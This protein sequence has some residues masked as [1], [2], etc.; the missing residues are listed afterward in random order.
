M[1]QVRIEGQ[2]KLNIACNTGA[3]DG[4]VI[5]TQEAAPE[6]A[7]AQRATL[8]FLLINHPLDCTVCDQAGHCKLQDYY[9]DYNAKASRFIENKVRKVK[10]EVLGPEIIY[11][12]ERCIVCTRCVRFCDEITETSELGV[13][14]RGDHAVIGVS[15]GQALDNPLAGSVV[16]LCPVGALTHRRWRFNTR[17]WYTDQQQSVCGGCST[18]CNAQVNLRDGKVVQVKA[19]LNAEVNQEWMCDEGRYGFERFQPESRLQSPQIW[20]GKE[21]API[22]LEDALNAT[23]KLVGAGSTGAMLLSP[24]LT[25]EETWIAL[26]YATK[27]MGLDAKSDQTENIQVAVQLVQRPLTKVEAVL[28]SPDYAP[29]A[30][31]FNLLG[32]ALAGNDWRAT[33]QKNYEALLQRV[34]SGQIKKLFIVGDYALRAVDLDPQLRSALQALECFVATSAAGLDCE[35]PQNF[36]Q[37]VLP[38]R[39]I[40][41]KGGVLVNKDLRLQ[42]LNVLLQAPA[43]TYPEWSLIKRMAVAAKQPIVGEQVNDERALF[44][45]MVVKREIFKGLSL[46]K[47]GESGL[48]LAELQKLAS[49]SGTVVANA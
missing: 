18:G 46:M 5:K 41:E 2:P 32:H 14:N 49:E 17:I 38:G 8:E 10:A 24:F 44:R 47:I 36:A 39:T 45:E 29:N 7:E 27:V 40:N 37:V 34:R 6:V 25:L 16:D 21:Y 35:G 26:E 12:G 42:R 43:G 4:M 22:K 28:I 31:A 9:Y 19:R 3:A 48:S 33:I 15:E 20:Q 1:C 23:Q 13:F 30:R 11:D